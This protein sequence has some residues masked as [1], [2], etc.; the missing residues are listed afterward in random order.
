MGKNMEQKNYFH[1]LELLVALG[2]VA[3]IS[4]STYQT[5]QYV[6][7]KVEGCVA[8]QACKIEEWV[9]D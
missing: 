6:Q 4:Y 1:P 3:A 7:E 8:Y 2:M 9:M 5:K